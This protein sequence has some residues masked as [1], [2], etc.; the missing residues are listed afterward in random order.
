MIQLSL[1]QSTRSNY[2]QLLHGVYKTGV[3]VAV[4][5]VWG[6]KFLGL[7]T[8]SGVGPMLKATDDVYV[9]VEPSGKAA[10]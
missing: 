5:L 10:V 9:A 8:S 3:V 4:V 6:Q 2:R 7:S 1:F